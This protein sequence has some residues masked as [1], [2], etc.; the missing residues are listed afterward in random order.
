[1]SNLHLSSPVSGT[2]P[3]ARNIPVAARGAPSASSVCE[4]RLRAPS[5]SSV[6]SELIR[7]DFGQTFVFWPFICFE[8]TFHDVETRAHLSG[9]APGEEE[10]GQRREEEEAGR[11]QEAQPPGPH[12]AQVLVGQL[13]LVCRRKRRR[14]RDAECL[15][16]SITI[17]VDDSHRHEEYS[18]CVK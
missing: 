16:T 11:H 13:D 8:N 10:V 7:S 6:M 4:L 17:N 18:I 5:A 12:P 14:R 1:L 15:H 9:H 2:E 3:N